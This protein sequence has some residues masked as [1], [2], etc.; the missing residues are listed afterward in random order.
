HQFHKKTVFQVVK[1][2]KPYH[3]QSDPEKPRYLE[4]GKPA[5]FE[6]NIDG[7]PRPDYS[8]LKDGR[9]YEGGE[10]S[11]DN[12]RLH[13]ARVAAEDKGVFECMATNRAGTIVYKFAAK[14][15]GAGA[16]VSRPFLFMIFMLLLGLLCCLVT[17]LVLYFKQ[18]K[19]AI[20]QERASLFLET[21]SRTRVYKCAIPPQ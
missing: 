2:V 12:R 15:K 13:I 3:T 21:K 19:T 10:L 4:Y 5:D 18:R 11:P 6:C 14:V 20:E 17:A 7:T 9:P 16:R 8:W 1:T